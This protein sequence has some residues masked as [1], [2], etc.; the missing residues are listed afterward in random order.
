MT[1]NR[2]HYDKR[3]LLCRIAIIRPTVFYCRAYFEYNNIAMTTVGVTSHCVSRRLAIHAEIET[4][5]VFRSGTQA[6][7]VM[8]GYLVLVSFHQRRY[9]QIAQEGQTRVVFTPR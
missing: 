8:N 4:I 2:V 3:S 7:D 5:W 6:N 9:R 1:R